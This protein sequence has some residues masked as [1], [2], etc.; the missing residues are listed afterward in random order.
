MEDQIKTVSRNYES[1]LKNIIT[2]YHI[3]DERFRLAYVQSLSN[4][5]EGLRRPNIQSISQQEWNILITLINNYLHF[6]YQSDW[7]KFKDY[8]NQFSDRQ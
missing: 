5:D 2:N 7:E 6:N 4:E 3:A 1:G 8:F